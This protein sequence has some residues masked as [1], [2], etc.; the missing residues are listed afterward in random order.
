MNVSKNSKEGK[1]LI[2]FIGSQSRTT[3]PIGEMDAKLA[4]FKAVAPEGFPVLFAGGTVDTVKASNASEVI[5]GLVQSQKPKEGKKEAETLFRC[6]LVSPLF[7]TD[8]I[9]ASG[10]AG[11][12]WIAKIIE[13]ETAHVQF[14]PIRNAEDG[15]SL[16]DYAVRVPVDVE[17]LI[18]AAGRDKI[19]VE[20]LSLLWPY[21]RAYIKAQK[22]NG[23]EVAGATL[24]FMPGDKAIA[25]VSKALR[26]KS[27]AERNYPELEANGFWKEIGLALVDM[28]QGPVPDPEA[29]EGA[30]KMVDA[31]VIASWIESRDTVNIEPIVERDEKDVN[32]LSAFMA[33]FRK[34]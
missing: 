1:A 19:D 27:W 14:R 10:D 25:S 21:F 11:K 16:E 30:E 15:E 8:S 3:F 18:T 24:R 20:A 9:L 31:S 23:D 33:K 22:D 26:S 5:F 29:G 12:D 17:S 4:A 2:A 6:L 13:K 7:S 34:E 32:A 28:A